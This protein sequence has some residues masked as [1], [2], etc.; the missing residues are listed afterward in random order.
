MMGSL[1]EGV[2]MKPSQLLRFAQLARP[3][4]PSALAPLWVQGLSQEVH[5][6]VVVGVPVGEGVFAA[7]LSGAGRPVGQLRRAEGRLELGV[8]RSTGSCGIG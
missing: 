2:A 3:G 7:G 5:P 1:K 4:R 6:T 8:R